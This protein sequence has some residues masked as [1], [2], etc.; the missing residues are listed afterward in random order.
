MA[1]TSI[2]YVKSNLNKVID[3]AANPEKTT[4]KL[5]LEPEAKEAL[6][7]IGKVIDYTADSLKTEQ[8]MYVSGI[9]CD[10]EHAAEDFM[11]TKRYWNKTGGRLA[12]HGYQ[13]FLEGDGEITAEQAHEIGIKLAKELWGDRFEVVVATHL[14]T[15]HYHNH[16]V[17]N[18]VS[19]ADGY[20]YI[21]SN[22]DY[23]QMREVSDR[24]C[25]E[26]RMHVIENPSNATR[27]ERYSHYGDKESRKT[28]RGLIREDIDAAISLSRNFDEFCKSMEDIGYQFKFYAKDGTKLVKPGLRP[29][30]AKGYFR[31]SGLGNG[32]H[33]EDIA[34]R[35]ANQYREPAKSILLPKRID[36]TSWE[37][38]KATSYRAVH[39]RYCFFLRVQ[40][41]KPYRRKYMP[42][43]IR[44]DVAKLDRFIEQSDFL[45]VNGLEDIS[46]VKLYRQILAAR[47]QELI[48]KRKELYRL[49]KHY[50]Y[51]SDASGLEITK[52]DISELSPKIREVKKELKL[53]DSIIGGEE[54]VIK[55][56]KTLEEHMTLDNK[57]TT[58][59]E[60]ENGS[61]ERSN[62]YDREDGARRK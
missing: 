48:S 19:F 10:P 42:M 60:N 57:E 8:R 54:R 29:P 49:K 43:A 40:V 52:A 1:V 6:N 2:W 30:E 15:G 51:K 20:K 25:R 11:F 14:N 27:D 21:R 12:Y 32:Y 62:G 41:K 22:A 45:R 47:E 9:N 58:G 33:L 56:C 34:A 38:S 31:F 53:C 39:R 61:R 59:K 3:Y 7:E 13:S 18:S 28:I 23:R 44:E 46:S 50:E 4:N 37:F 55:N 16:F 36:G 26:A 35:I 17:I 5:E 24:L